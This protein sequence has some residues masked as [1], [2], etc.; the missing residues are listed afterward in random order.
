M[1]Y[2]KHKQQELIPGDICTDIWFLKISLKTY[3]KCTN[4]LAAP[5]SPEQSGCLSSGRDTTQAGHSSAEGNPTG[6][7]Y[8]IEHVER[9]QG[10]PKVIH[11]QD[12]SAGERLPAPHVFRP[13]PHNE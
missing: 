9:Q 11:H 13:Q 2:T 5:H 6:T 4:R 7:T 1:C 12:A 8:L 3:L 10:E